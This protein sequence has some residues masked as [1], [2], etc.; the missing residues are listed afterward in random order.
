ML[1]SI[2]SITAP[3]SLHVPSQE[4]ICI[5]AGATYIDVRATDGIAMVLRRPASAIKGASS[6][7]SKKRKG[8]AVNQVAEKQT[9]GHRSGMPCK[10]V[11]RQLRLEEL[12][13]VVRSGRPV[14]YRVVLRRPAASRQL[15]LVEA[16]RQIVAAA[17]DHTQHCHSCAS[18]FSVATDS[19][20]RAA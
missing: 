12:K 20:C 7:I 11:L 5:R 2:F 8:K 14:C 18:S 16:F 4:A 1:A 15:L 19:F 17:Q 6:T 10:R 3:A 13:A 9:V